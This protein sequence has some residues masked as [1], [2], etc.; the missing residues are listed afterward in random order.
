MAELIN[1]YRTFVRT[2]R[3]AEISSFDTITASHYDLGRLAISTWLAMAACP[4]HPLILI[5][6]SLTRDLVDL[7]KLSN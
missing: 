3:R 6:H 4:F 7:W 2:Q 1:Y 5:S